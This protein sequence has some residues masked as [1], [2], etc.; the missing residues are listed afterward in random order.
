MEAIS[1]YN[2]RECPA[3]VFVSCTVN[4]VKYA[5]EVTCKDHFSVFSR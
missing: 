5:I 1:T 4:C 3:E 2:V